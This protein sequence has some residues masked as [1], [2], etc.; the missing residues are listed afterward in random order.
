[1]KK[2]KFVAGDPVKKINT[3]NVR[4]GKQV[5]KFGSEVESLMTRPPQSPSEL[6][7]MIYNKMLILK[8]LYEDLYNF[9]PNQQLNEMIDELNIIVF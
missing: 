7:G 3:L 2:M 6:S 1:M 4:K 9:S 5:F 8:M